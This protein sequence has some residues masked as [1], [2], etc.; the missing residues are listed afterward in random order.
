MGQW[1]GFVIMYK[2]L[3]ASCLAVATL[4]SAEADADAGLLVS[5]VVPAVHTNALVGSGGISPAWPATRALGLDS[6]CYGCRPLA[7]VHVI[8]KRSAEAEADSYYG[9]GY[10]AAPLYR[11]RYGPGIALHPGVA[12]SFVARSPQGLGKRSADAE[13]GVVVGH[14]VGLGLNNIHGLSHFGSGYTVSQ[15]HPSGHSFQAIDRLHKRDAEADPYY[16]YGYS[17]LGYYGHG[18][19]YYGHGLGYYGH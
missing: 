6:T 19:G 1:V 18:L 3:I 2:S 4:A 7:A 14:T 5:A 11:Y 15:L 17:R 13:P 8:H 10:L 12:T 16:G 9:Y